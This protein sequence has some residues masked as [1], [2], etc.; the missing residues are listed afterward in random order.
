MFKH[1]LKTHLF[2]TF[3][4]FISWRQQRLLCC[5][6]AP[7]FDANIR[8]KIPDISLTAVKF[9]DISGF[10][11][12]VVSLNISIF[13]LRANTECISL[14]SAGGDHYHQQMN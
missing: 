6:Y 5:H 8:G 4:A 1:C 14:K 2:N 12:Q 10:S 13:A 3:H 9:P 11:R 7:L